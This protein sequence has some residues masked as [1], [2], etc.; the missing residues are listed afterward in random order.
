MI[1]IRT[2]WKCK[3]NLKQQSMHKKQS[4]G[5]IIVTAKGTNHKPIS[6][7]AIQ[8][9]CFNKN[10]LTQQSKKLIS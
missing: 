1:Q 10:P 6:S 2:E 9:Q 4:G 5:S 3:I 7:Q 8:N